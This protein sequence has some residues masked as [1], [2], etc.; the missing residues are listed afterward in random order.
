MIRIVVVP[1]IF[2]IAINSLIL[3]RLYHDIDEIRQTWQRKHKTIKPIR[4]LK[5]HYR[6]VICYRHVTF[7][8]HVVCY[9]F[10]YML[11]SF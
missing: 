10:C 6:H 9:D 3:W 11:P 4:L 1:A 8:H 2:A 5:K 7:Y